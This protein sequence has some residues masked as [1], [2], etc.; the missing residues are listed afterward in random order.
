MNFKKGEQLKLTQKLYQKEGKKKIHIGIE[1]IKVEFVEMKPK[2]RTKCLVKL[3]EKGKGWDESTKS[4][5]GIKTKTGW[6]RGERKDFNQ[7]IE[8]HIKNLK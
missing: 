6:S 4:F 7:V 1:K 3:K 2:S 5:K 8:C